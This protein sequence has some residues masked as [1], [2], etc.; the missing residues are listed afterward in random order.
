MPKSSS[1]SR[2]RASRSVSRLRR[3]VFGAPSSTV[4]LSSSRSRA[5]GQP[6]RAQAVGDQRRQ[7]GLR[8][9]AAREVHGDQPARR[10]TPNAAALSWQACISVQAPISTISADS[11]ATGM[12][13]AGADITP[14]GES[15]RS[16]ASWPTTAPSSSAHDRLEGEP[17]LPERQRALQRRR[18]AQPLARVPA[19]A[20][21]ED[22]DAPAPLGLGAVGGGV[23]VGQQRV[24]VAA[25][26]RR[27]ARSR[28]T[29][30]AGAR[31]R[32][33]PAARGSPRSGDG[34]A[35]SRCS[36][37]CPRRRPRTRRRRAARRCPPGARSP[38][39]A[40]RARSAARRPR[41]ARR[42]R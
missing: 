28:S 25:A 32:R 9:L 37:R 14:P 24:G 42:G 13:S 23:G 35:R 8:E 7:V 19:Q 2:R 16:S 41:R 4:S 21:V 26:A 17:Q 29:P 15:Q 34:R 39:A 27:P 6:A 1:A 20:R 3:A 18:R 10:P 38:P 31:S 12:K 36:R 33:R 11:S 30:R 5:G 40:G 22:L